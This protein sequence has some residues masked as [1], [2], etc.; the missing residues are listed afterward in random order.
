LE[1][2]TK[3]SI[4]APKYEYYK[5]LIMSYQY[6]FGQQVKS[7]EQEDRTPKK[8]F[9]LGVY[10]SA[11]H[12]RWKKDGKT[13]CPALAVASEPRI[14]WDGNIEEAKEIISKISI[15]EEVG[16]L[17]PAGSHLNGPSAKVLDEHILGV[18]GFTRADAWLC[19]LLPETRLN[20]GQQ[21]VIKEIYN[22]KY[23]DKYGLNEVS[24]PARPTEFCNKER[25]QEILSELQ[26]SQASLL[27]LLGDIP[28]AQ[29]LN[30]V[31]NVPYKTLQE[32]VNLY[33]Y[34]KATNTIIDGRTIKVLPLAHPRQ[35][36]GL[37][38]HSKDWHDKHQEWEKSISK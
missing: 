25:C 3:R 13:I 20:S 6:P 12:A 7:L 22:K 1:V 26:E 9:V 36:G 15:P 32:Y 8:V 18:L 35:I 10:A 27:I 5:Y 4:F 17:E 38:F 16:T 23:K 14:F 33:G 29:F 2:P 24:I 31:A 21:R 37:G 19:D 30:E 34:G 11:V 28:I